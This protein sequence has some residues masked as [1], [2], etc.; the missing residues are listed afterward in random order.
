MGSPKPTRGA[1]S[2]NVA[3]TA[4][5][6]A[7]LGSLTVAGLARKYEELFGAPSRS[8]NKE[9]LRKRLAFKI[10]ELAE[11]GL[12]PRAL[13]RIEELNR[14]APPLGPRAAAKAARAP[15]PTTPEPVPARDPRLPAPGTIL[16]RVHGKTEHRVT[17]LD[18]GFEYK[19]KP[20]PS[21][22]RIARE[23]TGT[24]WNGYLFFLGRKGSTR[25]PNEVPKA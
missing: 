17:V 9:Y 10:Q 23:I 14:N 18:D 13:A 25:K 11:G 6:L 20:Y 1:D 19:G 8:R 22:S 7:A 2:A 15:E 5:D 3:K 16:T 21:L 12:S 24:S 4:A